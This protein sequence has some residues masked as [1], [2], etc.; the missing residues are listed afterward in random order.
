MAPDIDL[1]RTS[2][3]KLELAAFA[4]RPKKPATARPAFLLPVPMVAPAEAN[5]VHELRPPVTGADSGG[6]AVGTTDG[7]PVDPT[8]RCRAVVWS[9]AG[10]EDAAPTCCAGTAGPA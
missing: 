9:A 3:Q 4:A 10:T 7:G 5:V 6:K 2:N 1:P 8:A